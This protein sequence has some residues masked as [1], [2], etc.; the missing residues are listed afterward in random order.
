MECIN[1]TI[2]KKTTKYYELI[3]RKKG[4]I[5]DITD[6]TI[7]FTVK[8]KMIDD[9]V[10]AIISKDITVHEDAING[11]T[12]ITLSTSD[13]DKPA[14]NYHYDIKYKDEE[15]NIGVLFWGKL[16]IAEHPT[17]RD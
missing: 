15:N 8:E 3:F 12:V 13:T 10:D 4:I 16:R 9:D 11:K 14:G 2:F 17:Q 6:W 1:L 7:Y 5:E